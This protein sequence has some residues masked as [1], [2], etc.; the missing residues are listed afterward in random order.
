VVGLSAY[1][2]EITEFRLV[3]EHHGV[4]IV[5]FDEQRSWEQPVRRLLER[6]ANGRLIDVD[7]V[8]LVALE[9][10]RDGFSHTDLRTTSRR[11]VNGLDTHF[12]EHPDG[13]QGVIVRARQMG[14]VAATFEATTLL[15]TFASPIFCMSGICAGFVGEARLGQ[16][17]IASP[18]W[19][20]QAGKWSSDGFQIAPAQIPLRA[21]TRSTL[22]QAIRDE[23]FL[24][25]LE[26]GMGRGSKRPPER[27]P[28]EIAPAATGSAVIA[29]SRRVHEIEVQHRKVAAL[30]M[31]TFGLY[32]AAHESQ[33]QPDHY[34][35]VKCVVDLADG[36]KD[37]QLHSY[38]C[39]VA[40]RAAAHFIKLLLT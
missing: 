7:F 10:E 24:E 23:S 28:P 8:I 37:N 38:G 14:L 17:I 22:A 11:V 5:E 15:M 26:S 6:V 27:T 25:E 1:P 39:T 21:S 30:D 40:A 19:E 16:L 36:D 18:A 29:D 31:E 20:Y 3:F 4:L 33:W 13:S 12:V 35:S 32:Y 34:F 9:A 2:D